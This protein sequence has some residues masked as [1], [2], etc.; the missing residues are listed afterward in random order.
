MGLRLYRFDALDWTP[1][2]HPLERKKP[3]PDD[4]L[5]VLEFAPGFSDPAW[6]LL[7]HQGYVLEGRLGFEM[8]DAR[9]EIG[10]GQAFAIDPGAPHRAFTAGDAPVRFFI[11]SS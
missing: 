1:G 2:S 9:H 8:E 11:V 5:A 6:C 3:A 10:A 7:G 4:A